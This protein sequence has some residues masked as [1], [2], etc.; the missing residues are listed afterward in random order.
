MT[1]I[2][3]LSAET[4]DYYRAME[5]L[6]NNRDRFDFDAMVST[7]YPL[8]RVNEAYDAMRSFSDIKPVILPHA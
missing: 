8:S 7:R 6:R 2:G 3:S 5:F 4:A 1:V